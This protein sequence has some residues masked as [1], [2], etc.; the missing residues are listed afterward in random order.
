VD[1]NALVEALTSGQIH[2]AALDVTEPEPLPRDH[3]LLKLSNV[4]ITPH[5][6][7][8]TKKARLAMLQKAVD[9]VLAAVQ[10]KELP[11]EA[12]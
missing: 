3:P 6:G 4:I 7:S 5:I 10:G 2:F 12:L 1:Q 11:S 9:N 8:A